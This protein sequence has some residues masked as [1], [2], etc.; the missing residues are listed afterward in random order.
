MVMEKRKIRVVVI[1]DNPG[2]REIVSSYIEHQEDMD[3][4][5]LAS[6]GLE[7]IEIIR[8]KQPDVVI[9]DMIMPKLDGLGYWSR[10][11][12]IQLRIG[13]HLYVYLRLVRRI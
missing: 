1:D 8:E 13:L 10:L 3:V 6:N 9:L 12:S 2:I 7:G 11:I 5:G 4:V